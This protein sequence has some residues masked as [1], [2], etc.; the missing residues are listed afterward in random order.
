[1]TTS[2][3]S[4]LRQLKHQFR[5]TASSRPWLFYSLYRFKRID[6]KIIK[7]GYYA[8]PCSADSELVIE[9]YP[10]SANT[11]SIVAFSQAQS[12][13]VKVA[14]HLHASAQVLRGVELGLPVLVLMR[15]PEDAALSLMIRYDFLSAR[16]AL[17]DYIRFYQ[18]ISHLKDH[19]VL[20]FFEEVTQDFGAV[21]RRVNSFFKTDF[22][23]FD[24]TEENVARCFAT[25]ERM[26]REKFA[27]DE[28]AIARPSSERKLI[29]QT[30][31]RELEDPA[32]QPL[33]RQAQALYQAY[34]GN[35]DA[36]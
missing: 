19:F 32:L 28:A 4:F 6:P 13:P 22:T 17:S 31:Q 30:R 29:K 16:Q 23:P 18:T 7:A 36:P 21:I 34:G 20:G 2:S 24:H 8:L 15:K 10:R 33:L 5:A 9:G 3:P 14:H 12:R 27:G 25:I 35:A 11:F 1:M 26:N